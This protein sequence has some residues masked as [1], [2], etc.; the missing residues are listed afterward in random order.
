[1]APD[2]NAADPP[3][4]W[5]APEDGQVR[6]MLLGVYHMANPGLDEY[7]VEADDVLAPE[8]Q[9]ELSGLADRLVRW[10]PDRVAVERAYDEQSEVDALYGDYRAGAGVERRGEE[11]QIGYRVADRLDHDR[12]HAVDYPMT[13]DNDDLAALEDRGFEPERKT[14]AA[15]PDG[16]TV[17]RESRQRLLDATIPEYLAWLNGEDR[18]RVNHDLMFDRG[19]RW[20]EGDNFGGPLSLARWYDRNARVAHLLWRALEPGDE[21]ALLVVG[22]GHV[23]ALRHLLDEAPMLCPTSPLPYLPS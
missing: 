3:P 13:L 17:V 7:N 12:V 6:V 9:A 22:S 23:R 14:D 4:G 15:L 21:R 1:M 2:R 19:V 20:G 11:V 8:R 5:P 16:E 10:E 18:L